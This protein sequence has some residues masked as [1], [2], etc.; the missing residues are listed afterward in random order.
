LE[1]KEYQE[2]R[3]GHEKEGQEEKVLLLKLLLETLRVKW[4][5]EDEIGPQMEEDDDRVARC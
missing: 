3:R 4:R 2:E 1:R 5:K